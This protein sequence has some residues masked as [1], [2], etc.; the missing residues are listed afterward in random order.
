MRQYYTSLLRSI[1]GIQLKQGQRKVPGEHLLQ[2][3]S[4]CS[5]TT[6]DPLVSVHIISSNEVVAQSPIK[7][8][9]ALLVFPRFAQARFICNWWEL[10]WGWIDWIAD[11]FWLKL[12]L[13]RTTWDARSFSTWDSPNQRERLA[14]W[15]IAQS[16]MADNYSTMSWITVVITYVY[17]WRIMLHNSWQSFLVPSKWYPHQSV[18][19]T[20]A[21]GKF[22]IS[23]SHLAALYTED[24]G[25]NNS[26]RRL[27]YQIT[28]FTKWCTPDFFLLWN[29]DHKDSW[30]WTRQNE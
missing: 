25:A 17:L 24:F 19:Q 3:L 30:W 8:M 5:S 14:S 21:E 9:V 20:W 15:L 23:M 27:V 26:K 11:K 29:Y 10:N 2:F 13:D 1:L 6:I 18:C 7:I 12:H 22:I 4:H 16:I 28:N